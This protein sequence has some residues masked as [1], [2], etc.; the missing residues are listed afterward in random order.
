MAELLEEFLPIVL[1]SLWSILSHHRAIELTYEA[2]GHG[3]FTVRRNLYEQFY[4]R[5]MT[6]VRCP[7]LLLSIHFLR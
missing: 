3:P 2:L 4:K 7:V 1:M 6:T 5:T